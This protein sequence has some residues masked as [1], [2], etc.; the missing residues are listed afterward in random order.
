[1]LG[2]SSYFCGEYWIYLDIYS[3]NVFSLPTGNHPIHHPSHHENHLTGFFGW[4][5]LLIMIIWIYLP[6]PGFQSPPPGL[7]QV[8]SF[9]EFLA[10]K[11]SLATIASWVGP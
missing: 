10:I 9:G 8:F 7:V 2:V 3:T 5:T 6:H 11:S 4:P 1:M